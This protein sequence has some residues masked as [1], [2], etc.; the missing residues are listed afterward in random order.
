[1]KTVKPRISPERPHEYPI[2]RRLLGIMLIMGGLSWL[3]FELVSR[4][5]IAGFDLQ[6]ARENSAQTL[7][8]QRFAVS[9]VEV[10]GVNDQV[11]LSATDGEEV[12]LRGERRGFGW[13]ANA[14]AAAAAQITIEVEQQGDTLFV[15]VR[16]Q[17]QIMWYFGRDPY[18]SLELSLPRDVTFNVELVSGDVML[19]QIEAS[20]TITAVSGD[21]VADRTIG[22]LTVNTTGG[23]IELRDHR[24]G[25][26]VVTVG[27]DTDVS[28]Q[29]T[30]LDIQA[31]DGDVSLQG[32]FNTALID[33]VSGRVI[34]EATEASRLTI[35]TTSGNVRFTGQPAAEQ[36]EIETISGNV[37]LVLREPLDTR[38]TFT[39]VSGRINIPSELSALSA[40]SRSFTATFGQGR[41]VLKTNTTSGDITLRLYK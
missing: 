21:V 12:V 4:G 6:L 2:R 41:T 40:N 19:R 25:L 32:S 7:P 34:V 14:A 38:L 9:R 35:S 24:G 23:D 1:M 18:A 15:H 29:F 22:Q 37:D 27:G 11:T 16:R 30:D 8:V 31:I 13:A 26:K 20:G 5:S 36:Q 10:T 3:L 33:T 39:T 17:P 28:G